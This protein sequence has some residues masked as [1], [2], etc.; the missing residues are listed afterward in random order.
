LIKV[1]KLKD[2][3][4]E[5]CVNVGFATAMKQMKFLFAYQQITGNYKRKKE[6]KKW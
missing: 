2:R 5:I 3:E 6:K 4:D 1:E